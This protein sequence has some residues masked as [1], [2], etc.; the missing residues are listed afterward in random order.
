[1][2]KFHDLRVMKWKA[3]ACRRLQSVLVLPH[4]PEPEHILGVTQALAEAL[5]TIELARRGINNDGSIDMLGETFLAVADTWIQE[6][7]AVERN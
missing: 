7:T 3:D 1:M 2:S 4:R 6:F 5:A